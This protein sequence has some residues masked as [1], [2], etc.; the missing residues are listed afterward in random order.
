MLGIIDCSWELALHEFFATKKQFGTEI[1]FSYGP[2]GFL[3]ARAYHPKTYWLTNIGWLFFALVFWWSSFYIAYKLFKNK[4]FVFSWFFII[5]FIATDPNL[6]D[7]IFA[8]FYLF[9]LLHNLYIKDNLLAFNKIIL[10]IAITLISLIKFSFFSISIPIIIFISLNDF[11]KK[12]KPTGLI[13]FI[14]TLLTLWLAAGQSILNFPSYIKNN[15]E[16]AYYYNFAMTPHYLTSEYG[17]VPSYLPPLLDSIS[18]AYFFIF[19]ALVLFLTT[20]HKEKST[21]IFLGLSFLYFVFIVI[22]MCYGRFDVFHLIPNLLTLCFIA[23]FF[24]I[25]C[26]E[27]KQHLY[28]KILSIISVLL[29][30]SLLQNSLRDHLN[31]NLLSIIPSNFNLILEHTRQ[32]WEVSRGKIN[33]QEKYEL[34]LEKER[35]SF[36]LKPLEGSVD[37]HSHT[38]VAV[39]ANK[40]NYTPRPIFQS[41]ITYSPLLSEINSKYFSKTPP[42]YLLFSNKTIDTRYPT[43]DDSLSYL[44]FL[45]KYQIKDISPKS[46]FLILQHTKNTNTYSFTQENTVETTFNK[47]VSIPKLDKGV[48]WVKIDIE[49]ST[50]GNIFSKIYKPMPL[51]L[52]VITKSNKKYRYFLPT[53]MAKT[54]FLLSPLIKNNQDFAKLFTEEW[55]SYL[56]GSELKTLF[57]SLG[58]EQYLWQFSP[59]IRVSFSNLEFAR[60]NSIELKNVLDQLKND[61][62]T[63][64][65]INLA[66]EELQ[67]ANFAEAIMNSEK[68]LELSP[69]K[70]TFSAYNNIGKAYLSLS[71]I[72]EAIEAFESAVKTSPG[73]ELAN[74]NLNYAIKLKPVD[75]NTR[76]SSYAYLAEAY[77]IS[78]KFEKSIGFYEKAIKL[79][80][81]NATVY[82]NLS[83]AYFQVKLWDKAIFAAQEAIN[84]NPNLDSAKNILEQAKQKLSSS[85]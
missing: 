1:I 17:V 45:T 34:E 22:K 4:F 11:I 58:D 60:K 31:T 20:W 3:A 24:F 29:L 37:I 67:K 56:S 39:I 8:C 81:T 48:V 76:A 10:L 16:I 53:P 5:F 85:N 83:I 7:N 41:Y 40:F 9:F 57:I 25:F 6:P 27:Q 82:N 68:V 36:P 49:Y 51:Y 12:K 46:D 75:I 54:G 52:N 38:Q 43:L 61:D 73:S 35:D 55:P 30:F 79:G 47:E 69:S 28:I 64:K 26:F 23:T 65:L 77:L 14:L 32:F 2:Y 21:T 15:L 19:L 80:S 59:K 63:T 42:D 74:S 33:L 13:T 18:I 50:V 71:L 44:E 70:N 84:L 72:D 78:G 66:S 62:E